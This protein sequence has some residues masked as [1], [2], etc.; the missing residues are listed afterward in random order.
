M[1]KHASKMA[2]AAWPS[3]WGSGSSARLRLSKRRSW[4]WESD[5]RD[6]DEIFPPLT[7]DDPPSAAPNT[8]SATSCVFH[9]LVPHVLVLHVSPKG[10]RCVGSSAGR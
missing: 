6:E 9:V 2:R 1:E 4:T 7:D 10:K 8:S 5:D 3:T